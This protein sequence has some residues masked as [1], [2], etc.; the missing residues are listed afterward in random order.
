MS[1]DED[2]EVE[3]ELFGGKGKHRKA[4]L[5]LMNSGTWSQDEHIEYLKFVQTY[6]H[7]FDKSCT[8]SSRIFKLMSQAIPTRSSDQCR[9]HHNKM[10]AHNYVQNIMGLGIV[11]KLMKTVKVAI[12]EEGAFEVKV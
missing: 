7:W 10:R 6:P 12:K 3:Q 2:F 5:G 1:D 4:P 9:S 8:R 11:A